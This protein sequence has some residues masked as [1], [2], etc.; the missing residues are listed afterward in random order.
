MRYRIKLIPMILTTLSANALQKGLDIVRS[1]ERWMCGL[2]RD[3]AYIPIAKDKS[4][5]LD[6]LS[7]CIVVHHRTM[8]WFQNKEFLLDAAARHEW[9][10]R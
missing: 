7:A 6:R 3:S 5:I 8:S 10:E 2:S 9:N 1:S 4:A